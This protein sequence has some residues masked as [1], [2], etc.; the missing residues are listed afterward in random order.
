MDPANLEGVATAVVSQP[1]LYL[2]GL[3]DMPVY[4]APS[5]QE[6]VPQF[7]DGPFESKALDAGHWLIEDEEKAVI[8]AVL[9][10]LERVR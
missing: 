4:V 9:G 5:V 3:R 8:E 6:R 7:V 1:V 10:H 2:Y